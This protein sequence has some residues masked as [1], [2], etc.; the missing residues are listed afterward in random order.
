MNGAKHQNAKGEER[1]LETNTEKAK[2]PLKRFQKS[3]RIGMAGKDNFEQFK[4]P[5]GSG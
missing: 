2:M 1:G 3:D 5:K 4:W